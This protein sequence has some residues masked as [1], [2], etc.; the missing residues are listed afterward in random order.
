MN[1]TSE[2]PLLT[3]KL[4]IPSPYR[5]LVS[6]PRLLQQLD[7]GMS[8]GHKLSLISAPAGFGKTTLSAMWVYTSSRDIAWLSLDEGDN[9]PIQFLRYLIAALQ[10]I[11]GT[12]GSSFKHLLDATNFAGNGIPGAEHLVTSL[13][14]DLAPVTTPFTLVLEDYHV[15]TAA[16]VHEMAAFLIE[17]QPATMHIVLNTRADPPLPLNRWRVRRQLT[18]IRERDLQFTRDEV[19]TFFRQAQARSLDEDQA[20]AFRARTEG[21]AAGLQLALL[22]L[23]EGSGNLERFIHAF[24]GDDRHIKDYLVTEVLQR[25]PGAVRTFL[26]QTSI[27][28]QFCAGLCDAV[29]GRND[30]VDFLDSLYEANLFLVVLDDH[31]TWYRYHRLFAESLRALVAPEMAATTHRRAAAWYETHDL[32]S[33]AVR[34][35]LAYGA[36]CGDYAMAERLIQSIAE[37]TIHL[38]NLVTARRWLDDLPEERILAKGDLATYK[39]WLLALTGDMAKAAS[40]ARIAES[41]LRRQETTPPVRF[42]TPETAPVRRNAALGR[43]LTLRAFI[44]VL[45][46]KDYAGAIA[47]A[48]E[49]LA[50]LADQYPQ[51][52]VIAL[53]A[54]AESQERTRPITEAI[55]TFHDA[56]HTGRRLSN[57]VSTAMAE[58]ALVTALN[59]YG[60]RREAVDTCEEAIIRHMGSENRPAPIAGLLLSRMGT[61]CY[62]ANDLE[63]AQRYHKHSQELLA[64]FALGDTVAFAFGLAAPVS[65]ALGDREAA[66]TLLRRSM[67]SAGRT[68]L[69]GPDWFQAW[70]A[71]IRM[72]EGD[73]AFAAEWAAEAALSPDAAP[74][75]LH[76]EE[77]LI[78]SRLLLVQERWAEAQRWLGRLEM[79]TRNRQ[80]YRWLISVHVQQALLTLRTGDRPRAQQIL[81]KALYIAA[82]EDYVRAFLDEDRQLEILLPAVRPIAPD[83]V[84]RLLTCYAAAIEVGISTLPQPVD[85]LSGRE[86]EVL[87]LVAN[88]LSNREIAET[89]FISQGTV[90]RHLN[91]IYGKLDVHRRTEAVAR[92]RA[93][94][95]L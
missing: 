87:T 62:E 19:I 14:H 86:I 58:M 66:L 51:W 95:L 25:Q 3:A 56:Q 5:N 63:R 16:T 8:E 81:A 55:A 4:Y 61:L 43:V 32:P 57:Q 17:R 44:T 33:S 23:E 82:P 91:N 72:Q 49:A 80:L 75:Y 88:G 30:S 7:Q 94:H 93:L 10:Q 79:F 37:E 48:K 67:Q 47:L 13:I 45:Y 90:K 74:D 85:P 73:I 41:C 59:S 1:R 52:R 54:L 29:T 28:E 26:L 89:L 9:D 18:E 78:F 71:N 69:I 65:Y 2:I 70:E 31:H 27:L 22:T 77:G 24:S 60:R 84:H 50:C 6:R 38:G 46:R 76:I 35:A 36:W 11:E 42:P 12:I 40:Y 64:H 15:I 68:N 92:A 21:W 53:W 83:F 20:E 39:G 34:H